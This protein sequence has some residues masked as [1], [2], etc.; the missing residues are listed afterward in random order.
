[1]LCTWVLLISYLLACIGSDFLITIEA[2]LVNQLLY[3]LYSIDLYIDIIMILF[4]R[5]EINLSFLKRVHKKVFI[6]VIFIFICIFASDNPYY[7]STPVMF[8]LRI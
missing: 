5:F 4:P 7:E 6:E 1:M 3:F 2:V 8:N